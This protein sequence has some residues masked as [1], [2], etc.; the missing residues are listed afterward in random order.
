MNDTALFAAVFGGIILFVAVV[1]GL[2]V[3]AES[4][5]CSIQ[6]TKMQLEY[7]WGPL[8]SCMVKANDKWIPMRRYILLG[9]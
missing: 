2:V 1:V 8:Q 3:W 9:N 7:S 5:Q 6:A 4:A